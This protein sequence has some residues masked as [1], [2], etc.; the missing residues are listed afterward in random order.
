VCRE[1]NHP[2]PAKGYPGKFRNFASKL[3][4]YGVL[5]NSWHI[6]RTR[7]LARSTVMQVDSLR[8][9]ASWETRLDLDTV[10]QLAVYYTTNEHYF[11]LIR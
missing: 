10:Q 11:Y 4:H 2:P 3:V 8:E 7:T 5:W 9:I 1:G 6:P